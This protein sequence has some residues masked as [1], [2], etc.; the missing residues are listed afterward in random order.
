MQRVDVKS[1]N[2]LMAI[3]ASD[4]LSIDDILVDYGQ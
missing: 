3:I 1:D 2:P 4:V